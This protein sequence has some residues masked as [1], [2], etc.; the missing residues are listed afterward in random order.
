MS[1]VTDMLTQSLQ[2]AAL[3]RLGAQIGS[4]PQ[5][6]SAAVSAAVPMLVGA[7]ARNS[8]SQSGAQDLAAALSR[9]HDGSV[10]DNVGGFLAGGGSGTTGAGILRHMFGGR[11]AAV[12]QAVAQS[13][14][15]DGAASGQLLAMLAPLVMAAIG[16]SARQQSGGGLDPSILAGMLGGEQASLSQRA[17]D[18]MGTLGQLLD[19]NQ[20][21]SIVDDLGR[22]A[23]GFFGS[24]TR[25]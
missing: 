16:R 14:G 6:T 25:R 24:G 20:D 15:L 23:S 4:D 12:E 13:S 19:S 9:D 8:T 5:T 3:N 18:L 11:Q 21:G 2:G 1:S 10:L 17:P 7:L 22:L